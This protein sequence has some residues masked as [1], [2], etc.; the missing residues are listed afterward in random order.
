MSGCAA[1][2]AITAKAPGVKY[3][4]VT[5]AQ[6]LPLNLTIYKAFVKD[7]CKEDLV[8]REGITQTMVICRLILVFTNKDF[9]IVS[10][11]AARQDSIQKTH[12]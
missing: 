7:H 3:L 11:S 10:V 9:L 5:S 1:K 6:Y 12:M 2:T 4:G 8:D